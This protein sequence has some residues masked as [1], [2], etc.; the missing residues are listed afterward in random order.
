MNWDTQ[1]DRW[2]Q[3]EGQIAKISS[4]R[5][6]PPVNKANKVSKKKS[7]PTSTSGP[8]IALQLPLNDDKSAIYT[9]AQLEGFYDLRVRRYEDFLQCA[10]TNAAHCLFLKPD[11]GVYA[12]SMMRTCYTLHVK[13]E[14]IDIFHYL[15][16]HLT[17][18]LAKDSTQIR[19]T[20]EAKIR[21]LGDHL[22]VDAK[23]VVNRKNRTVEEDQRSKQVPINGK[24]IM[25]AAQVIYTVL[26]NSYEDTGTRVGVIPSFSAS[27]FD[28]F[29]KQYRISYY[30]LHGEAAGVDL[31]AIE[32]ELRDIR[33]L[34]VNYSP[35]DIY[36]CDETG[37]Y[38]KELVTRSYTI[39]E[40]TGGTKPNRRA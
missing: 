17:K 24:M 10:R 29:K 39:P 9:K 18:R 30:Q 12:I 15:Q 31:D 25:E 23:Y 21:A 7:K 13:L 27:W 3:H 37:V 16:K 14:L 6:P 36:N 32:P 5:P 20:I 4:K 34:C 28:A 33:T 38:L 8:Y 40:G 19:T 2:T 26:V 1:R 22:P 35:D 11:P